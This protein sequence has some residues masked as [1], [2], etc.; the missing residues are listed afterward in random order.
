MQKLLCIPLLVLL[1]CQT[2]AYSQNIDF[3][4]SNFPGK[5]NELS[6]ADKNLKIG[7]KA[8]ND[9]YYRV[10][11][12]YYLRANDFN[13]NSA[14]LN[15]NIGICYLNSTFKNKARAHFEKAYALLP[16]VTNDIHYWLGYC[17]HLDLDWDKA[18][19]EYNIYLAATTL[20]KDKNEIKKTLKRLEECKYGRELVSHPIVV[21]TTNLGA[22]INSSYTDYNPILTKDQDQLMFTSRRPGTTTGA[23]GEKDITIDEYWEDIY[24]SYSFNSKWTKPK[25]IGEPINTTGH[26]SCNNLSPNGDRLLIYMDN[27][28]QGDIFEST[29]QQ[30]LTWSKPAVLPEPI[31]TKY[32]ES[33]ASLSSGLDSLFFVSERPG[34]FG[35]KDIY[36]GIRFVNTGVWVSVQN[37]GPNVNS[38]YDEESVYLMPDGKTLYFSSNGHS[39]MG[40]FDI[41]KSDLVDKQ[42]SK[43]K[44]LGYPLNTADDDVNFVMTSTGKKGYYASVKKEGF[45]ERDLYLV[46]FGEYGLS[47]DNAGSKGFISGKKT[48]NSAILR[49]I[50][51]DSYNRKPLAAEL[52]IF[53]ADSAVLA[54]QVSTD[55]VTGSYA[56]F[57][58]AG[59]SYLINVTSP[60]HSAATA[61]VSM[62]AL[63]EGTELTKDFDLTVLSGIT[64]LVKGKIS[65]VGSQ[66]TIPAT[67]TIRDEVNE[68]DI[69]KVKTGTAGEYE[70]AVPAGRTYS[71]M[72]KSEGYMTEYDNIEVPIEKK[73]QVISKDLGL[74]S[75]AVGNKIILKN[76]FYDFNKATLRSGSKIELERLIEVLKENP[77]MRIEISSHTDNKGSAEYNLNLSVDRSKS[78][79]TYLISKGIEASRLENKGYGLS[80]PIASNDT[81]AGRQMN[82]RTEFR[83]LSK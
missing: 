9:G 22:E 69:A 78:V 77:G 37:L 81:E 32:H 24:V 53:F 44:N 31:N 38:E 68:T 36:L 33:S 50:V 7:D 19:K 5:Q 83:I 3:T 72:V 60:N 61:N 65:D 40:G 48:S 52:Q 29:L 26:E 63:N 41:F 43:P 12:Q 59:K 13:P 55:P 49:G 57:L 71:V 62:P 16:T 66:Q 35:G 1:F 45:G 51:T 74:N 47:T 10:A 73:G 11:L 80:Q 82:R 58:P 54:E 15:F 23:E 64:T 75:L 56:V 39:S 4:K 67:I 79:V 8:F 76:I 17:Y 14:D 21:R 18:E 46:E 30:D 34:G 28:G 6:K 20:A 42:W 25:N 27:K 2:D 70:V